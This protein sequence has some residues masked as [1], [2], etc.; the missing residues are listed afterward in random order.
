MRKYIIHVYCVIYAKYIDCNV[1]SKFKNIFMTY[2]DLTDKVKFS[3]SKWHVSF[4]IAL[5]YY[6]YIYIYIYMQISCS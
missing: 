2:V 6:V 5:N 4:I 1:N 3:T